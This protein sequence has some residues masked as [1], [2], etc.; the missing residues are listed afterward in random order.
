MIPYQ[1]LGMTLVV[2]IVLGWIVGTIMSVKK[3]CDNIDND[4]LFDDELFWEIADDDNAGYDVTKDTRRRKSRARS[5]SLSK[6]GSAGEKDEIDVDQNN[7]Q[8]QIPSSYLP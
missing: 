8:L 6:I 7:L 5:T 3:L 1:G 2:A 4:Q